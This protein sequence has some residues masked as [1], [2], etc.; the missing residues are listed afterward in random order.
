MKASKIH[1]PVIKVYFKV[2]KKNLPSLLIYIAIFMVIA[3]LATRYGSTSTTANFQDTKSNVAFFDSDNTALTKGL[4]ASLSSNATFVD[5]RDDK[6]ALCDALFFHDV[7]YI[8]RIPKGFTHK[9]LNGENAEIYKTEGQNEN[10]C[11][12]MN[13]AI[14]RYLSAAR[15]CSKNLPGISEE[16]LVKYVSASVSQK[17][18]V[19]TKTY[20]TKGGGMTT[21]YNFFAYLAYITIVILFMGVSSIMMSFNNTDLKRRNLVSPMKPSNM[22]LQIF[23][24]HFIFMLVVWLCGI[25]LSLVICGTGIIGAEFALMCLNLFTLSL[26]CLSISFLIGNSV[27]NRGAQNGICNVLSLALAFVSGIFVPQ[28]LLSSSMLA[29]AHFTPTYWYVKAINGISDLSSFSHGAL[30][31]IFNAMLIQLGFA[32]A[33]FAVAM[34]IT[35]QKKTA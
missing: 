21:A 34:A 10:S 29:V 26:A 23:G 11:V 4:K 2:I 7:Q 33:I 15:L 9:F 17:T 27:K 31:P 20:G 3:V 12:N 1:F 8:V 19:T 24:G 30:T 32:A 14:N 22:S 5:I 28:T 25:A 18:A 16:Q 13:L 35:R 6:T